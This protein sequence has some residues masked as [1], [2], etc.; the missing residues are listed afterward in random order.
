[1]KEV[2]DHDD[3]MKEGDPDERYPV[4]PDPVGGDHSH[5]GPDPGQHRRQDQGAQPRQGD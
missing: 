1:M 3:D 2:R 4:S 5:S